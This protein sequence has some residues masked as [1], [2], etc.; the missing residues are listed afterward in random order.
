M[1]EKRKLPVGTLQAM[2][3]RDLKSKTNVS[4]V[5]TEYKHLKNGAMMVFANEGKLCRLV[6]KDIANKVK[7]QEK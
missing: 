5:P 7:E 6:S 2:T 3:F 4:V 1:E